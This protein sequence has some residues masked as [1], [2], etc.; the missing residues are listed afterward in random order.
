MSYKPILSTNLN[1]STADKVEEL[2]R[3]SI[4]RRAW[5]ICVQEYK[6]K[7]VTKE[8]LAAFPPSAWSYLFTGFDLFTRS[9]GLL[10]LVRKRADITVGMTDLSYGGLLMHSIDI[11]TERRSFKF[12][13]CYVKPDLELGKPSI[14]ARF[15]EFLKNH[16]FVYGDYNF[17]SEA[18]R[19]VILDN[20]LEEHNRCQLITFPTFKRPG[21]SERAS[22]LTDFLVSS[23]S[24]EHE[25]TDTDVFISDHVLI[26]D[27]IKFETNEAKPKLKKS[28]HFYDKSKITPDLVRSAWAELPKIPTLDDISKLT[29]KLLGKARTRK[30]PPSTTV[31]LEFVPE[32]STA[33]DSE[34]TQENSALSKFWENTCSEISGLFDVGGVFRV[35]NT[36]SSGQ[37]IDT[38]T[39]SKFTRS[40][41]HKEFCKYKNRVTT[42]K[43]LT[44]DQNLKYFR[45]LR[46]AAKKY[47]SRKR[48]YKFTVVQVKEQMK[49]MN[50]DAASGLDEF[51]N[52]FFPSAADTEGIGKLTNLLNDLAFGN[53]FGIFLPERLKRARLA[54]VPK[55]DDTAE[56]RP[57]L[58]NSRILALLDRLVNQLFITLI[59]E[60][61]KFEN[62]HAFRPNR[63]CESAFDQI[64][65]F[66]QAARHDKE[67]VI[68]FQGDLSG[69]FNSCSHR[70]MILKTYDLI[71]E[72]NRH[73]DPN[74]S[75]LLLYL[76]TWSRRTVFYEKTS[77]R[78]LTGVPQGSPLSPSIFSVV[79]FWDYRTDSCLI[80]FYADDFSVLIRG[81]VW[82]DLNATLILILEDLETWCSDNDFALNFGKSKIMIFG[83]QGKVSLPEKFA[84]IELVQ[85]LRVLG[86][87]FDSRLSFNKY[88]SQIEWY[89]QSRICALKSLRRL[90]L[91]DKCLRA[92][93]MCLRSKLT[94]GLYH[95]MLLSDSAFDRLE[96]LWTK[97]VRAWTGASRFVST[98][99]ML[100]HSGTCS[101]REFTVYLLMSRHLKGAKLLP[102]GC[103]APP[104]PERRTL[105]SSPALEKGSYNLRPSTRKKTQESQIKFQTEELE[106]SKT[107]TEKFTQAVPESAK[108]TFETQKKLWPVYKVKLK[109]KSALRIT[110][111][112]NV[113]SRQQFF[114]KCMDEKIETLGLEQYKNDQIQVAENM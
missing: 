28:H 5:S 52:E 71:K 47:Q 75:W 57:I 51:R 112:T 1:G 100:G 101:L 25:I 110:F 87:I 79:F 72:T 94:F 27:R 10:T 67:N 12:G 21:Q 16:S 78:L 20:F 7:T 26:Q 37:K 104:A 66:V 86:V 17:Q 102:E 92:A 59:G 33:S 35:I 56:T 62:R 23:P 77:F 85:H 103:F 2:K 76:K 95:L 32:T 42:L 99:D 90:G 109:L 54:L 38:A 29:N 70:L 88:L 44:H 113:R 18:E 58:M 31:Q 81:S 15:L 97:I 61:E 60:S 34:L 68:L 43:K 46:A 53:E 55:H 69:A 30:R 9:Q 111:R 108:E 91:S 13:N 48:N 63:G 114:K 89:M 40:Q 80:V 73:L 11:V 50:S 19:Q 24:W 105:P 93:A 4:K 107:K 64:L 82:E 39:E 65:D 41:L 96:C 98:L 83:A 3:E 106:K 36:F 45:I 22:T 74:W 8:T 14:K 6:T 84:K 49:K